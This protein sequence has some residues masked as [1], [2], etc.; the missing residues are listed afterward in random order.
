MPKLSL[1]LLFCF[2]WQFAQSQS[3]VYLKN[4]DNTLQ[5]KY[6]K[7]ITSYRSGDLEEARIQLTQLLNKSPRFIDAFIQ[8]ASVH[9]DMGNYEMADSLFQRAIQLDSFYNVKVFYTMALCEYRSS[10]YS[11]SLQNV[12]LFLTMDSLNQDLIVKAKLLRLQANFGSQA[13][14]HQFSV[15]PIAI[16]SLNS[17]FSEYLPSLTAEG[18][19]V[20]FTR[21]SPRGDENIYYSERKLQNWSIPAPVEEINTNSNEGSPAISADGKFLVF[22]SC[23]RP[24]GVGGCDL[25]WSE[26]NGQRWST[27]VAFSEPINSPAYES[28]ACF[29]ANGKMLYFVSNRKGTL[30]GLDIWYAM[31]K[32]NGTWT[33]PKNLGEPINTPGDEVC[34]FIHFNG[35]SFYFASDGHIGLG[36]KDLFWSQRDSTGAWKQPIN[37][38]IPINSHGDESSW[39]IHPDGETAWYASDQRYQLKENKHLKANL[40][41]FELRLPADLKITPTSYLSI[42]TRDQ[43]SHE[44]I[45]AQLKIFDLVSERMLVETQTSKN[46]ATGVSVNAGVD[47]ALHLTAKGYQMITMNIDCSQPSNQRLPIKLD[48][49][50]IPENTGQ[51]TTV[52]L[53][54][55]FFE[56]GSA[57]LLP[58]S[59]F[60]L[61]ALFRILQT[62]PLKKIRIDAYTDS[63]GKEEDNQLLSENRANSVVKFLIDKGIESG[64]LMARGLGESNPV[65]T[66]ATDAGRQANRRIE[67]TLMD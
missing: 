31:R 7:A 44:P 10:Q 67:F 28:Q 35:Q 6:K 54:N 34:P 61:E 62:Q 11:K 30:G 51:Q 52:L 39:M 42:I 50:M 33:I 58:K 38:G 4:A 21:R 16:Q 24:M 1:V 8:L 2:C 40:D 29:S 26:Y 46:S 27:P 53:N 14:T 20:F 3:C 59:K 60:E 32:E 49:E 47:Y 65:A 23:D 43:E 19:K 56:S 36:G 63:V 13:I 17:D 66:N 55:V 45:K 41:L 15:Q 9:F 25:F 18:D 22:T 64:R 57:R 5:K 37:M 48:I 12:E